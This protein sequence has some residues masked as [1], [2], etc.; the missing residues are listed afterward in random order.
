MADSRGEASPID[1]IM[2]VDGAARAETDDMKT[3]AANKPSMTASEFLQWSGDLPDVTR[4]ELVAGQP[5]AM[6]PERN[7]HNL[8]KIDCCLALRLAVR[9]RQLECTVL[10]DGATVVIDDHHVYEPDVTVQ[11]GGSIDVDETVVSSP[12]ILVEVLSPSTKSVDS[13]DKLIGYFQ[14]PSVEHYLVVDPV[15]YAVIHHR[16]SNGEIATSLVRE[17]LLTLDPPGI[18]ID[19]AS[20]F[21]TLKETIG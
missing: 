15:R 21:E 8:V 13:S 6:P 2:R 5:I 17:G 4:H 12:T 9:A 11:C 7:R 19:I 10:G 1:A 20:F 3:S 14:L 18:E 16:R